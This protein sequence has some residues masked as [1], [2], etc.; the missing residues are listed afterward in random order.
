MQFKY[1][2]LAAFI[3]MALSVQTDTYCK[4]A[5]EE[6]YVNC[7]KPPNTSSDTVRRIYPGDRFGVSRTKEGTSVFGDRFG[8]LI[9]VM[10]SADSY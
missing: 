7:R 4:T 3:C 6:E 9:L 2:I 8:P 10:T 5:S 1:A